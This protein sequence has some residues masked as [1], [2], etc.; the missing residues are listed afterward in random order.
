M[1]LFEYRKKPMNQY[2]GLYSRGDD[3]DVPS[4]HFQQCQNIEFFPGSCRTRKGSSTRYTFTGGSDRTRYFEFATSTIQSN[5]PIIFSMDSSG[6][7]YQDATLLIN[8]PFATDFSAVQFF[9][10]LFITFHDG[11]VGVGVVYMWDNE[12]ADFREIAGARPAAAT[13]IVAVDGAVTGTDEVEIGTYLIAVAYETDSGFITPPGPLIAGVFTPTSYTAPGGKKI[14]LSNIPTGPANILKRHILITHGDGAEYFFLDSNGGL[15]PDNVTTTAVLDFFNTDLVDSADYLFDVRESVPCGTNIN[16]FASRLVISGFDDPDESLCRFSQSGD[17]ETF[18]QTVENVIINKDDGYN[19]RTMG[20]IRDQFYLYKDVGVYVTNDNGDDPSNWDVFTVEK[21]IGAANVRA[22]STV[23]AT[24]MTG[25]H[26]DMHL[27]ADKSGLYLNTGLLNFPDIT[28]KVN[29]YWKSSIDFTKVDPFIDA[30][31]KRV[32]ILGGTDGTMLVGDYAEGID[33]Q[34]IKWSIWKLPNSI[35]TAAILDIATGGNPEFTFMTTGLN[36]YH[37]D[38]TLDLDYGNAVIDSPITFGGISFIEGYINMLAALKA[39]VTGNGVLRISV[40]GYDAL[41]DD[42][43]YNQY[44]LGEITFG[45]RM[46]RDIQLM[47]RFMSEKFYIRLVNIT[48]NIPNSNFWL[49]K[50]NI[51]GNEM[52]ASRPPMSN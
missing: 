12:N 50:M 39:R 28:F 30:K 27:I 48:D 13:P 11:N 14:N 49:S 21:A 16:I 42:S 20:Q 6:N 41:T 4:N 40:I 7:F 33:A 19:I 35:T 5:I 24:S 52:Y 22:L 43:D 18:D 25:A 2:M 37:F 32:Y 10:K 23:S 8:I 1:N 17:P 38:S 36:I 34:A 46:H 3:D 44:I 26:H 31:N 9:N 45:D 29:D 51:F 47:S 15:I